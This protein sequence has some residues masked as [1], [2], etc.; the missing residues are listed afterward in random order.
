MIASFGRLAFSLAVLSASLAF[1][2]RWAAGQTS[3]EIVEEGD[4]RYQVTKQVIQRPVS[5]TEWDEKQQTVYRERYDTQWQTNYRTYLTPVTEYRQ[6]LYLANRWNPL[7][8][9]Y[10]TYR[11]VPVTRWEARQEPY[12]VPIAQRTWVPEQQT[13]RIPRTTTL[14]ATEEHVSKMV[15]GTATGGGPMGTSPQ[16]AVARQ[17]T[18]GGVKQYK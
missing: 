15:I 7:A 12:S 18:F 13:V 8:T 6:E 5:K 2:T 16:T 9:P 1:S 4:V 3:V 11:Y 17:E 10:W 14:M